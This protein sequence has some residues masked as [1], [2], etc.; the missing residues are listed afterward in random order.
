MKKG[1]V[2]ISA[3]LV[4]AMMAL[5][6]CGGGGGGGGTAGTAD[7]SAYSGSASFGDL[8][9]FSINRTTKSYAVHNETTSTNESGVYTDLTTTFSGVKSIVVGTNHFYA[10]ELT[11][12][13]IAANFPTGRAE[14][15]ISFGVSSAIDN[16]GRVSEIAGVYS[17]VRISDDAINGS[18]GTKEWGILNVS[19]S[20][21]WGKWNFATR[22]DGSD[23]PAMDPSLL[24]DLQTLMTNTA[25]D[26]TGT[27]T[28]SGTNKERLTVLASTPTGTE[29][30][31]GFAY[32]AGDGSAFMVD[33]GT[34]N[35]F[36]LGLKNP[37]THYTAADIAGTYKFIDIWY[38]GGASYPGAGNYTITNGGVDT[39][40][41]IDSSGAI[42][43]GN[44]GTLTPCAHIPNMFEYGNVSIEG[45]NHNIYI[46]VVGNIIMHFTF[47]ATVPGD[48]VSYGAGA[49]I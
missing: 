39:Y 28:V 4:L 37:T 18:T 33:L 26:E 34:G 22:G 17:W 45:S 35:G 29:T 24:G 31:T 36:L 27:W 49:K 2:L 14:N 19:S 8:V 13:I 40:G 42:I 3:V 32:A 20:G 47:D 6:S 10:V 15:N 43:G 41:H 7:T 12:K 9:T 25:A 38:T 21:T 11:D 44:L 46:V 48:F 1:F 23:F 5:G 30:L 16:S